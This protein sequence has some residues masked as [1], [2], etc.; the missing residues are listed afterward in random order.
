MQKQS[1]VIV[2]HYR[3]LTVAWLAVIIAVEMICIAV[4]L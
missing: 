3:S 4:Q 1:D 2:A